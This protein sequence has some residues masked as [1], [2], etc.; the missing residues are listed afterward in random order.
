MA[1]ATATRKQEE[2]TKLENVRALLMGLR[3]GEV[4]LAEVPEE[5][6]VFEAEAP[7]AGASHVP[8]RTRDARTGKTWTEVTSLK[9]APERMANAAPL[10]AWRVVGEG[11]RGDGVKP[12][13]PVNAPSLKELRRMVRPPW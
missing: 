13:E 6:L 10:K 4:L 7:S 8:L 12:A 11:D 3:R 2:L 1:S 5:R 9:A